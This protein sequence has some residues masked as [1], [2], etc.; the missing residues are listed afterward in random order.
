[1]LQ[2]YTITCGFQF[3]HD[4]E[5]AHCKASLVY[6]DRYMFVIRF[7]TDA[8]GTM[9]DPATYVVCNYCTHYWI[10]NLNEE[11]SIFIDEPYKSELNTDCLIEMDDIDDYEAEEL[12]EVIKYFYTYWNEENKKNFIDV[13]SQGPYLKDDYL[14]F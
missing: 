5:S 6:Y 13:D 4:G 2:S 8:N 11:T 3:D 7:S 1:M 14:P 12:T 9:S 10:A